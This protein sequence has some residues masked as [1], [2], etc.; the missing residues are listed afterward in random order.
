MS[1]GVGGWILGAIAALLLLFVALEGTARLVIFGA[2]G[3]DPRR[4][5]LIADTPVKEFVTFETEPAIGWEYK[6]NQ[7][8]FL[9]LVRLRTNSRGMRDKEY[10]LA[11]PAGTFRVA[12]L[13]SSFSLPAGV[14]IEDA[15]HSVLEERLSAE[16]APHSYEFLNLAV[17][18]HMPS[19][20]IAMLV[21][22]ALQFDPDLVIV[23]ATQ[24][25]LPHLLREWNQ[26]PRPQVLDQVPSSPRSF[27]VELA[28]SRLQLLPE[29]IGLRPP[30][31]P[32]RRAKGPDAIE[33]LAAI[34]R[35]HGIPIVLFRIA[36]DPVQPRPVEREIERRFR[37][38]GMYYVDSRS[39]FQ[40]TDPRD[41][42]VHEFDPHPD[43]RAHALFADVLEAFLRRDALLSH[44]SRS[45]PRDET[46]AA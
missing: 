46:G 37:S 21:H 31:F 11:K 35:Q 16:F 42:W 13:G 15:Y 33:K 26:T 8:T 34:S 12:V 22:R 43:A 14:E 27:L 5:P 17:G 10:P 7:D 30:R 29:K 40:G 36:F 41:W 19:Q 3:L 39:A 25:A 24:M 45:R 1:R 18:A 23:S 28:K 32:A 9:K 20:S 6:P 4:V 2:A 44:P 38:A